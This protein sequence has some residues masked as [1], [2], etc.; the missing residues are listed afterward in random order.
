MW[1]IPLGFV[2]PE[3]GESEV[4]FRKLSGALAREGKLTIRLLAFAVVTNV[5]SKLT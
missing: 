4:R 1:T 2:F 3:N 5:D